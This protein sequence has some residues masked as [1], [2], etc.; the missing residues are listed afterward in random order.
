LRRR[1]FF[2]AALTGIGL[3]A[4][5][6]ALLRLPSE[7]RMDVLNEIQ[8]RTLKS[9]GETESKALRSYAART[10]ERCLSRVSGEEQAEIVTTASR[11]ALSCL[12]AKHVSDACASLLNLAQAN[13]RM[14]DPASFKVDASDPRPVVVGP[15]LMEIGFELLYWIPYLRAQLENLGVC[16]QR[17]IAVSRGGAESWYGDI[18]GRYLDLLDFMT[19]REFHDWTSG[20]EDGGDLLEGNRKPFSAGPFE[21]TILDRVLKPQGIDDYQV[22]MPSAMYGLF[23]NIWRRRLGSHRFQGHLKPSRLPRPDPIELPFSGPYVAV[24]FYN[25]ST[26]PK[27]LQYEALAGRVVGRLARNGHVVILSNAAQLDD[28]QTLSLENSE[29]QFQIFDASRLYT[30]R[31]NLAVQT[32]LVAHAKELHCTYG[33]FSYLGPLLGVDTIA[34]T[35]TF[36]FIFTHLDLAWTTFDAIGGGHLAMLPVGGDPCWLAD[37]ELGHFLSQ[38][39]GQGSEHA[40]PV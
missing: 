24:K 34:Y 33:G 14:V 5:R 22:I 7:E 9:M 40:H 13:P 8:V 28:H 17:V 15:W 3:R 37:E 25:S 12:D 1:N 29:G 27:T 19:P 23:R 36:D 4:L 21:T 16:K 30:P 20:Q 10:L 6:Q 31:N 35:G 2:T 11:R 32:A 18:A 38:E 26:F 39:E